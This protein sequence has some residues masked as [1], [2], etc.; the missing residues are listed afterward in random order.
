MG[1]KA[2]RPVLGEESFKAKVEG[3]VQ[4][5]AIL[6]GIIESRGGLPVINLSLSTAAVDVLPH[7]TSSQSQAKKIRDIVTKIESEHEKI[8]DDPIGT[9]FPGK[10]PVKL[11]EQIDRPRSRDEGLNPDGWSEFELTQP[12]GGIILNAVVELG[13]GAETKTEGFDLLELTFLCCPSGCAK[14]A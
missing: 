9:G 11:R 7:K 1:R 3:I 8:F 6:I 14:T 2:K 4:R 12:S 5:R 10:N 13:V